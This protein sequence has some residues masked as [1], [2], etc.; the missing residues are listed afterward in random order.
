MTYKPPNFQ[1]DLLRGKK[2]EEVLQTL[3][4]ELAPSGTLEYD[5]IGPK[6]QKIEIK[7]DATMYSNYFLE[8]ISNQRKGSAGGPFQS[9]LKGVDYYVYIFK[10]DN[11]PHVFK[12]ADLVWFMYK[13]R[14]NYETKIVFNS[15][16][17]TLG[18]A[19]PMKDVA[20][21]ELD[22]SVLTE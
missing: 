20:H 22:L 6:G 16:Y 12:V 4:P 21:L 2:G 14:D 18:H 13:Q 1:D 8:F 15:L 5:L 11:K 17:E 10:R 9:M 7:Y 3:I 19:I